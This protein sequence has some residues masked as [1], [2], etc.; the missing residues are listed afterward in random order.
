M[1]KITFAG[2]A[3]DPENNSNWAQLDVPEVDQAIEECELLQDLEER[4]QCWG[5]V[6]TQVMELAP[7][8]MWVWDN[9]PNIASADVAS[10]INLFNANTDLSFTSLEG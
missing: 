2:G 10:V 5:D 6:D 8:L 7:V 4:P 9:Q 3:I 1:F